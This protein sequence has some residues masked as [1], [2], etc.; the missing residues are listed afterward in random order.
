MIIDLHCDTLNKMYKNK[1]N[2]NNEELSVNIDKMKKGNYLLQV[3]AMFYNGEYDIKHLDEMIDIYYKNLKNYNINNYEQLENNIKN[4]NLSTIL[5]LEDGGYIKCINDLYYLHNKGVKLICITWNKINSLGYPHNIN[6]PLTKLGLEIIKEM[7][8]LNMIICVSHLSEKGFYDVYN[9][10]TKPFI[11]SHS[12]CNSVCNHTRNLTDDMIIKIYERKGLIGINYYNKFVSNKDNT[13]IEDLVKHIN[14]IK[15]IASIDIVSLGSDFDGIDN[16]VEMKDA[17]MM[18][19][20]EEKLKQYFTT[21]EIEKIC[22]KNALN[23][24]KPFLK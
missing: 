6:K 13:Y 16:L 1:I 18:N 19:L 5:S 23:F 21:E 12:N 14:Y 9:T 17:S 11:A 7:D 4:N 15:K 24:L 2:I 3:F 10:T 22:Y 8:K 20:F